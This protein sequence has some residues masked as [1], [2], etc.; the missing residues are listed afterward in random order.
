MTPTQEQ[1]LQHYLKRVAEAG[2]LLVSV[3]DRSRLSER[4]LAPSLAGLELLPETGKILDIGSGGGF[5][6]I[7]LAILTP[8]LSYTLVESNSRKAAFLTR[9]S[10]ETELSERVTILNQ[11]VED[12]Q[13]ERFD[14]IMA[15]AVTELPLLVKWC[16]P[17]LAR[18]G[19]LLFWKGQNWR[20]EAWPEELGLKL[21]TELNLADGSRLIKLIIE[22]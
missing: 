21:L 20:H 22:Q 7:P 3:A 18:E 11:R 15:R 6:A 9:V 2:I 16:R 4:H 17:L 8:H 19:C 14:C 5:P 1:H 13:G 10:R 12:L